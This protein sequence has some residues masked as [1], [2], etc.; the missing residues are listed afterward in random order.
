MGK[1]NSSYPLNK[2]GKVEQGETRI[3]HIYREWVDAEPCY[4]EYLM[5]LYELNRQEN[6]AM[7]HLV[8]TAKYFG[9]DVPQKIVSTKRDELLIKLLQLDLYFYFT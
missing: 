7:K 4:M 9:I 1:F 3:A 6:R 2:D 8:A 5:W